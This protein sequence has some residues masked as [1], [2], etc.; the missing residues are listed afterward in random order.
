M[1]TPG[2][3]RHEVRPGDREA[4]RAVVASTGF[5]SPAEVE[6]ADELVR[7]RLAAGAASGYHFVFLEQ[8]GRVVAYG[9]YGPIAATQASYD[10][11][12]IA[13]DKPCQSQ[14]LGRAVLEECERLIRA[15][16]GRRVYAETSGRP[17]YL[18]TRRFY[19][20][21]GYALEATL[22]DFYAPG[23]DKVIYVKG[24]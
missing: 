8:E 9:C 19:E 15:A 18:P 22:R 5:F 7:E 13:V 12:W 10:L 11:Y 17:Q 21:S 14:G 23:D 2:T 4:V 1:S 24:L 6:V 3:F 20:R 16:G